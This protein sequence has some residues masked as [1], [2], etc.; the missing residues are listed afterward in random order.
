[1]EEEED[2]DAERKQTL[3]H[4]HTHT[5][6]I[7]HCPFMPTCACEFLSVVVEKTHADLIEGK[8]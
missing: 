5:V 7:V 2:E 6:I 1:M 3:T 8:K 4:S